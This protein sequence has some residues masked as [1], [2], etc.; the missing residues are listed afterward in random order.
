MTQTVFQPSWRTGA[1]KRIAPPVSRKSRFGLRAERACGNAR[2]RVRQGQGQQRRAGQGKGDFTATSVRPKAAA[3]L[4]SPAEAAM[5]QKN[6]GG[7]IGRASA[8]QV[9]KDAPAVSAWPRHVISASLHADP[10]AGTD[11]FVPSAKGGGGL[12]CEP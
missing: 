12:A 9:A 8:V 2:R 10:H 4:R 7:S 11:T 6:R 3:L 1:E 5:P